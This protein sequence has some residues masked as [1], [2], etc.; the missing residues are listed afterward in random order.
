MKSSPGLCS[1]SRMGSINKDVLGWDGE[2]FD[3][4]RVELVRF[5]VR[6][7]F[8]QLLT[9]K[10]V[11]DPINVFVKQEPHKRQKIIDGRFRL[12]SAVSLIDTMV[13]RILFGWLG[14]VC[15]DTVGMT[16]SLIGWTVMNG[17]WRDLTLLYH[18]K[19]VLCLDKSTWDWTVPSWLVDLWRD[20]IVSLAVGSP[21]WW[22]RLV[23]LRFKALFEEPVFQFSD[24]TQIK[25]RVRGIMKSGC[26]LTII[27]N[28]VGQSLVHYLA[29]HR[30]GWDLYRGQPRIVGDDTVQ[31]AVLDLQLYVRAIES[32]GFKVKGAKVRSWIEFCGFAFANNTCWPAYW[33]KHLFSLKHAPFLLDTLL[34][35]QLIY[36]NEPQM[37]AFLQRVAIDRVGPDA[38]LPREEAEAVFNG[39]CRF[40][41]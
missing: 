29:C 5:A 26:F 24:G 36:V 27:L 33:R 31:E 14:R 11:H 7:R 32:L 40:N 13:D 37:F 6:H 41:S 20:F 35:Y 3:F 19:P 2:T 9:G 21:D 15:L 12:I 28:T 23:D 22:V 8:D 4:E 17:G 1:L 38:I 18:K 39:M 30:L 16:P 10:C 34:S 25:Q